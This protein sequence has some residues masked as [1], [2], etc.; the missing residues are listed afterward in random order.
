[1]ADA[2]VQASQQRTIL[3]GRNRKTGLIEPI[4]FDPVTGLNWPA[5]SFPGGGILVQKAGCVAATWTLIYSV[6]TGKNTIVD[7]ITICN[8]GVAIDTVFV[9]VTKG[10]VTTPPGVQ[11]AVLSN[12]QIPQYTSYFV[13]GPIPMGATDRIWV[14]DTLGTSIA[15]SV[16]GREM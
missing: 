9:Y 10:A 3:M 4:P 1:M 16:F 2:P 11:Y 12:C 8:Y 7:S 6:P 13:S 15:F 5:A 14:N